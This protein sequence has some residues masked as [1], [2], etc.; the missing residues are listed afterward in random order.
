MAVFRIFYA[1]AL[2]NQK[3]A[4]TLGH[5]SDSQTMVFSFRSALIY[6]ILDTDI[7][8]SSLLLNIWLSPQTWPTD[9]CS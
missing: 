5:P 9:I 3:A 7:V 2:G 4:L 8:A 6:H 1:Q